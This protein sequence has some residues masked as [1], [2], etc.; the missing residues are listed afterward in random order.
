MTKMPLR[1][2][3]I[4]P[5]GLNTKGVILMRSNIPGDKVSTITVLHSP[6]EAEI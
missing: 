3:K 5:G 6:D 2:V 4:F 1:D